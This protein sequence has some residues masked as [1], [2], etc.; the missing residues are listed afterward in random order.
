MVMDRVGQE[1]VKKPG[2]KRYFPVPERF[3][4]RGNDRCNRRGAETQ[5][6]REENS[7]GY[8]FG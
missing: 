3:F 2:G 6:H 7:F 5:R 8:G 1:F 4:G